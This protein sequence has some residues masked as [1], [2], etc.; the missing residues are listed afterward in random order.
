MRAKRTDLMGRPMYDYRDD[1]KA[2]RK[3]SEQE[4]RYLRLVA[5][6]M[7]QKY[8]DMGA[9][10]LLDAKDSLLELLHEAPDLDRY[11]TSL[12]ARVAD[13]GR[14]VEAGEAASTMWNL[15]MAVVFIFRP[16]MKEQIGPVKER[17]GI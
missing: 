13:H 4:W 12:T 11:A 5:Q 2:L 8:E 16:D 3:A 17:H 15:M 7:P 9:A 1:K 6:N 10:Y 14:T